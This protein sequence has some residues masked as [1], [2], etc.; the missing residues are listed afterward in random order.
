[1]IEER[2]GKLNPAPTRDIPILIGGGGEKKTLRIVAQ[3]ADIWHSFS[4]APTLE[5]KLGIL[6]QHGAA[7]GRDTSEIEVSVELSRKSPEDADELHAVGATLF[8]VGISGPNHNL[9]RVSDWLA[10]RDEKNAR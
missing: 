1:V 8:T 5:R 4:D 10:W 3:H 2:W 7:V 9:A 6:A